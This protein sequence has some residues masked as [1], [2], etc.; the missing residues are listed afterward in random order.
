MNTNEDNL[1]RNAQ[2]ALY[3]QQLTD[4]VENQLKPH[5]DLFT[6]IGKAVIKELE[7]KETTIDLDPEHVQGINT[8][9]NLI[10]L[11]DTLVSNPD[12]L[13]AVIEFVVDSSPK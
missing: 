13:K 8:I 3:H 5:L 4:Q 2:V 10:V 1:E 7:S 12:N 11:V 9:T 6:R